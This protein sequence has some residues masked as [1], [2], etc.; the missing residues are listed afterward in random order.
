MAQNEPNME[1]KES[2]DYY[3][4]YYGT[5]AMYQVG[6]DYWKSWNVAMKDTLIKHQLQREDGCEWGSWDPDVAKWGGMGGRVY[7][8]AINCLTLEVT[9]RYPRVFN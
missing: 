7:A 1:Q 8:T 3:Y 9:F 4:W 2:I 5:L 6:K